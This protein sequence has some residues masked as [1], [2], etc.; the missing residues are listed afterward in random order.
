MREPMDIDLDQIASLPQ[1]LRERTHKALLLALSA[2]E[3][4]AVEEAPHATGNL[5][6]AITVRAGEREGEVYV[7]AAAP[8][9]VYVHQGTGLYGP[10]KQ[11]IKPVRARALHF[12]AGGREVFARQVKGQ[13]PNPFMDRAAERA[14]PV[15]EQLFERVV[16][17]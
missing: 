13:R 10:L 2:V 16:T 12:Q 5:A 9:A 1:E 8:Y 7:S 11:A 14:R 15:V 6:D 4:V 3:S 17:P